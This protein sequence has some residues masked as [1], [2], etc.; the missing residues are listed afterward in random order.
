MLQTI[1][2][3]FLI[4]IASILLA[5]CQI[6]RFFVYNVADIKDHKKFKS[7]TLTADSQHYNFKTTNSGKIPEKIN[8]VPFDKYLK[9]HK[10][11][12]FLIIKND[13]LQYEKYFRDYE[14]KSIVPSFSVA[15]S[16][17][18][19][20]I[21]CAIDD[22]LIKSV[23]EPI[24]NY[25]PELTKNGFD[26][27]TIKH[28][29]QMTSGI[30][31]NE[32]YINPFGHAA[33]FYYG[34]DLR[35]KIKRLKL[36]AEPGKK[37]QYTS[38]NTQLLGLIL[39]R[40][41]KGKTVTSYLQ[42]KLWTPLEME[43]GASWSIDREKNGLEKTFCCLNATAR[44]F[45]KIGRLYKNKGDWNGKQIISQK[46]IEESTKLDTTDGSVDYYQYQWWLPTPNEDFMAKGILGQFIYVNPSKD[47]VI[48]RLGKNKKMRVFNFF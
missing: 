31:F 2:I 4:I 28:V 5:S 29:L 21:G 25:I 32:S 14:K 38:G 23:D 26:K 42:E 6:G 8:N 44:D 19:I 46:W 15:K 35:K 17:T 47:L 40:S 36:K 39:E 22:G 9:D 11:V 10:T 13:T 37:F 16:V 48:V 43:Y 20:L 1:R 33:A 41:L 24:T 18:S 30:R 7:R 12:A 34:L 27:V 45:A 3:G